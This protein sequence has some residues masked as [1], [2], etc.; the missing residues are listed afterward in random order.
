MFT[1]KCIAWREAKIAAGGDVYSALTS[2]NG[3]RDITNGV[4]INGM[5][6][7]YS[8]RW[9]GG[10]VANNNETGLKL[11]R[12]PWGNGDSH[13]GKRDTARRLTAGEGNN[14]VQ[15]AR[16]AGYGT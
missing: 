8:T 3:R 2:A 7:G 6:T 12:A 5:S 1:R 14:A 11:Y 15:P 9:P 10:A 16:A 13:R 4:G